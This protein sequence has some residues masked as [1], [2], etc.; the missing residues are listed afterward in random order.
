M[1]WLPDP[2]NIYSKIAKGNTIMLRAKKSYCNIAFFIIARK[3]N[4]LKNPTTDKWINE[5][6]VHI[7]HGILHIKKN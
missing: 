6:V 5:N 7:H 2:V 4:H 3:L 1:P